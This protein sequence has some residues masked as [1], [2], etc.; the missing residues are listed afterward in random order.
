MSNPILQQWV[1]LETGYT[2]Q[3]GNFPVENDYEPSKCW[4]PI[5]RQAHSITVYIYD[6]CIYNVYI[7]V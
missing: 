4:D 3:N 6:V 5:F 1:C 7:H 2:N